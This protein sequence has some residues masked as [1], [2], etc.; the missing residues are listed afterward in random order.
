MARA[1]KDNLE[2]R[3][4]HGGATAEAFRR[5]GLA[6]QEIG[7]LRE[8]FAGFS[9]IQ[10]AQGETLSGITQTLSDVARTLQARSITDWKSLAAWA[11]VIL[12]SVGLYTTLNLAP[13]HERQ[14]IDREQIRGLTQAQE[15]TT[16]S[17]VEL[18]E[19]R[20]RYLERVDQQQTRIDRLEEPALSQR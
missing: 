20:G 1:G 13:I 5:L 15:Q 6:E 2:A 19:K 7:D 17:M 18:A 11:G 12:M 14:E 16:Q 9:A 4:E 10:Q 8:Q 3:R